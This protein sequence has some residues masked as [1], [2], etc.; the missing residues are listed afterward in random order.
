MAA[1]VTVYAQAV[2]LPTM[3]K[4][5]PDLQ[6]SILVHYAMQVHY[7]DSTKQQ[8]HGHGI[9]WGH[10]DEQVPTDVHSLYIAATQELVAPQELILAIS[11]QAQAV[12]ARLDRYPHYLNLRDHDHEAAWV[13]EE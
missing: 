2:V 13:Q 4:H 12:Y 3:H 5:I 6:S 9:V 7:L 10:D 1:F 8:A 11:Y